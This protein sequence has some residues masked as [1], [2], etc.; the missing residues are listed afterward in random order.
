MPIKRNSFL[1]LHKTLPA[2]VAFALLVLASRELSALNSKVLTSQAPSPEGRK[3]H[4]ERQPQVP[5]SVTAIRNLQNE[6]WLQDI[7]IEIKNNSTKSIYFLLMV[8][9]FP[10]I[11]KTTEADGMERGVIIPLA[12]GRT[13]LANRGQRAHS[14]DVPIKPGDKYIFKIAEHYQKGLESLLSRRQL[15]PSVTKRLLL[16]ISSLRFDDGTGYVGGARSQIGQASNIHPY[17]DR[18][19]LESILFEAKATD[20]YDDSPYKGLSFST[21]IKTN[22]PTN[23]SERGAPDSCGP[24]QSGCGRYE[25]VTLD[26]PAGGTCFSHFYREFDYVGDCIK[27]TKIDSI[28]CTFNGVTYLCTFDDG[29]DCD[30]YVHCGVGCDTA[31]CEECEDDGGTW[32]ASTCTCETNSCDPIARQNCLNIQ[33]AVW[34]EATCSCPG[35]SPI[36]V[37]VLGNGFNLTNAINGVNFD[38]DSNGSAEHLSWTSAGSDDAFLALD[39]NGDGVIDNG[40]ELFGSYTQQPQSDSP[41]GFL[42][43][44][45]YDKPVNGG[46]SDG[47][48]DRHDAI[49][50]SLRLWQD[51]NHNGLSEGRELHSLSASGL[52]SIELDYRESR[53]VDQYGNRFRYRAKVKDI[54]GAQLGR[55]AWDVYFIHG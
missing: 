17:S 55:W 49:F 16:R 20:I 27:V 32:N 53:R 42:A 45:E 52:A 37:D 5:V 3:V 43:L 48:I 8:L 1:T 2:L 19:R 51:A 35:Y 50:P 18:N 14:G 26:C 47:K 41:N 12:Y 28:S 7:E 44:A 33:G 30:T 15:P 13:E 10:D 34:D 40:R 54:H 22:K 38:L 29:Y 4:I 11:P 9:S 31:R 6:N 24:Y 21:V 36:L 23:A 39:R 46:N 25:E